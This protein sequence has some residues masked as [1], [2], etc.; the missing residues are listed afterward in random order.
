[1]NNILK[2][3]TCFLFL[4]SFFFIVPSVQA[5]GLIPCSGVDCRP[6]H[7]LVL[8]VNLVSFMLKSIVAPLAGLMFLVGGIMIVSDGGS[9]NRMKKGK[10]IIKNTLIGAVIALSAWA[11]VN[12]LIMA[13]G[14]GQ[15]SS[16]WW[17]VQCK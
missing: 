5:A 12:T 7:I 8:I 14:S 15:I 11:I 4:V 2:N 1:M 3:F 17:S 6:C 10:E 16:N 9:G 13:F